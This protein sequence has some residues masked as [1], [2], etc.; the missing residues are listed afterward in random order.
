MMIKSFRLKTLYAATVIDQI[1]Q[2]FI[3]KGYT[4]FQLC[5]EGN[6]GL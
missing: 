4:D 6:L 2:Q 1:N 5:I 3:D